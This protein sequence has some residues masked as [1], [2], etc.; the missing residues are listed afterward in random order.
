MWF[1][2][3]NGEAP[4]VEVGEEGVEQLGELRLVVVLGLRDPELECS[5]LGLGGRVVWVGRR[6]SSHGVGEV[7]W[8]LW[9]GCWT[10]P[11]GE[12]MKSRGHP[13][14][15][16]LPMAVVEKVTRLGVEAAEVKT[17]ICVS[18]PIAVT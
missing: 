4:D 11:N 6:S 17:C 7:M 16:H 15:C 13:A 14:T 5:V 18:L 9:S 8:V 1:L 10:I 12:V 2:P 3:A